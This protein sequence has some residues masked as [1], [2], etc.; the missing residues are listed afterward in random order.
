MKMKM[1]FIPNIQ[2]CLFF[3][4]LLAWGV[5]LSTDK[6]DNGKHSVCKG[7]NRLVG[8]GGRGL[9]SLTVY[10]LPGIFYYCFF[11]L[12]WLVRWEREQ[13]FPWNCLCS[14]LKV[15]CSW[16]IW[17]CFFAFF[18]VAFFA[19]EWNAELFDLFDSIYQIKLLQKLGHCCW[20]TY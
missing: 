10:S 7:K 2:T 15:V 5:L 16:Y 8:G 12:I 11:T 1:I 14:I 18:V 4:S 20:V 6:V 17:S 3:F 13:Y 9:I 19:F